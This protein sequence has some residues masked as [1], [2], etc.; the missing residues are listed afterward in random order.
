M[1]ANHCGGG[2]FSVTVTRLAIIIYF[3][4]YV[5]DVLSTYENSTV[6]I[7]IIQNLTTLK[8]CLPNWRTSLNGKCNKE[9]SAK[10]LHD[11][12]VEQ[13]TPQNI[14][15]YL[16]SDHAAYAERVLFRFTDT[17]CSLP[18]TYDFIVARNHLLVLM[19]IRRAHRSAVL[20]K[21]VIDK[22]DKRM[23]AE[24]GN[25]VITVGTNNEL[26]TVH[27]LARRHL[28]RHRVR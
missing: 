28:A 19:C 4:G 2:G 3:C 1:V 18:S 5:I 27:G 16:K 23:V 25:I 22:Y 11:D 12:D 14:H 6:S 9:D 17:A 26:C 10:R 21:L 7:K 20:L 15:D 24:D 13:F 8:E